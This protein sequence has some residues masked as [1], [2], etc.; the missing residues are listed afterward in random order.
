MSRIERRQFLKATVAGTV[1]GTGTA[2]AS[3][4]GTN[5]T[6]VVRRF[7]ATAQEGFITID[8]DNAQGDGS[9]I[10]RINF[11]GGDLGGDVE[12]SGDIYDDETWQSSSVDFP[13]INIEEFITDEDLSELPINLSTDDIDDDIQVN[14]E[15]IT[16]QFDADEEFMT[17]DLSLTVDAYAKID[18]SLTSVELDFDIEINALLTT[19][20]SGE[21]EGSASGLA[22]RS[23]TATLVNNDYTVPA[24]GE[25][26]GVLGFEFDI[27]DQLGLPANDPSRNYFELTLDMDLNDT[28]TTFVGTVTDDSG[29]TLSGI[30][31][32]CIDTDSGNVVTT[33]T[34]GSDGSY[35]A[36]VDPGTYEILVDEQGYGKL[37]RLR[38]IAPEETKTVDLQLIEGIRDPITVSGAVLGDGEP[39]SGITVEFLDDGQVVKTVTSDSG[40]LYS[41]TLTPGVYEIVADADGYQPFSRTFEANTEGGSSKNIDISLVQLPGTLT[42]TV[43]HDGDPLSDVEITFEGIEETRSVRSGPDGGYTVDLLPGDYDVV[44]ETEK[45]ESFS[46]TAAVQSQQTQTVDIGLTLVTGTFSG[47]VTHDGEAVSDVGVEFRGANQTWTATS[48][49]NG[50]YDIEIPPDD[51]RI[52]VNEEGFQRFTTEQTLTRNDTLLVNVPLSTSPGTFRGTVTASGHPMADVELRFVTFDRIE[53]VTTDGSGEYEIQLPPGEYQIVIEDERFVPF[54]TTTSVRGGGLWVEDLDLDIEGPPPIVGN[55]V[56]RDPDGDG[57]YESVRGG[58]FTILDVQ[59]LFAHLDNPDLQNN[60]AQFNF[61]GNNPNEV[62]ILDV[63]ALFDKLS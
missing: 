33:A 46:T 40:G 30:E 42:G 52:V 10:G 37:S 25:S 22:T 9:D 54:T 58:E 49:E 24:T 13:D 36:D 50:D 61:Y 57:N 35:A 38:D 15:T 41:V 44:V 4:I 14:V 18:V 53:T 7:T 34:T 21:L 55:N 48:G 20:Q 59:A 6:N 1:V 26:V 12:I 5:S 11:A 29:A 56:P 8:A 27:D 45:F 63:Q 2:S 47:T 23:G 39:L 31:I 51:Y 60:A 32:Q 62:S 3:D 17:A 16:G 28:D 43:T 19:G